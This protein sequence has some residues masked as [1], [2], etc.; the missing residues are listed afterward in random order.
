MLLSANTRTKQVPLVSIRLQTYMHGKNHG[1]K[2]ILFL[3]RVDNRAHIM[4]NSYTYIPYAE[5][6][7]I[8]AISDKIIELLLY[9]RKA[10]ETERG[11]FGL[12]ERLLFCL[13]R[14]PLPPRELMEMLGMVKSNLA[15]LARKC[16]GEGLIEKSRRSSDNRALVYELTDKG[17]EYI[18]GLLNQIESKLH[19]VLTTDKD[20][21]AAEENLDAAIELLSYIP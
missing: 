9:T 5:V 19:T 10:S 16:I 7:T 17:N 11:A 13:R 6:R 8:N 12:K 20:R 4:Y 1:I 21:Q 2:L 14:R 18:D 15:L 3:Y